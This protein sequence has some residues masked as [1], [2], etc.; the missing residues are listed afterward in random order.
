MSSIG[1]RK[2]VDGLR[3]I[4]IVPVILYHAGFSNFSGG[5]YGVD[6][7]FVVSGYLI[8]MIII[9]ELE[10]GSFKLRN[11]Y[12]RRA[13][14][15]LPAQF[16][17]IFT[18]IPLAWLF[19]PTD[20][21]LNFSQS[22]S[23][24]ALF[25]SNILFWREA[26]YFAPSAQYVPLIHTWSLGIEAQFYVFFSLL[27]LICWKLCKSHINIIVSLLFISSFSVFLLF[28]NSR[29]VAS[30]YLLPS[31]IW[32]LLI[33][34]LVALYLSNNTRMKFKKST[35]E[36]AGWAG[37]ALILFPIFSFNKH[38]FSNTTYTVLCTFGTALILIF[39]IESTFLAKIIGNK[40]LVA[41][42][43]IS[44]SLY[45]WHQPLLVFARLSK[46]NPLNLL[47]YF[48]TSLALFVL[49]YASW[50]FIEKPFRDKRKISR[51]V[52][53]RFSVF[54]MIFLLGIGIFGHLNN[55]FPEKKKSPFLI[56]EDYILL[57]NKNFIVFGDSHAQHLISG[58]KSITSG[59]VSDL[60]SA[61][62]I[63]F[64]NVDRYDD[65]FPPGSCSMFVNSKLDELLQD[66]SRAIIVLSSMG[67]VYLDG[68]PFKVKVDPR[69][70]GLGVE[71]TTN[72]S[73]RDRYKVFE[74]GLRN[75]LLEL[76]SLKHSKIIIALDIPELG[77]EP[78]C[79]K[80]SKQMSLGQIEVQDFVNSVKPEKC[81]VSRADFD[82]RQ[83]RY[84]ELVKSVVSEFPRIHMFD[85]AQS[86]CN[87]T[88]CRGLSSKFGYL[89]NDQDH[90]SEGGSRY[91]AEALHNY[92]ESAN[93]QVDSK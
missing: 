76:S 43:L 17:V 79:I 61:G 29:P 24:A 75:T 31:R 87:E 91:Y 39:A 48:W 13:R 90:L 19:L 44:Y 85:P 60:T 67:S 26:S 81:S 25:G 3:A 12:E 9:R 30:F 89:Y 62:C 32:E 55:G 18:C 58:I 34:T 93:L 64:R 6:V 37:L 8:T 53:F 92:I 27:M 28:A 86:F 14:R 56:S 63:P 4:A 20:L 80:S 11:F 1:Y 50:R 16:L 38:S 70:I 52:F 57:T 7:F 65:R 83:T 74:I 23:F 69:T 73:I 41:V 59:D 51:L 78:S 72:K 54:G 36:I 2:E 88:E 5:Y 77:I 46:E 71:L 35:R 84:R 45:L 82:N 10:E 15:I 47:D 40:V 21:Y 49:A 33:G 66:D 42:G 22:I 68:T